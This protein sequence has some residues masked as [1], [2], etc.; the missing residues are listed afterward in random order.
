M[1]FTHNLGQTQFLF[2]SPTWWLTGICTLWGSNTFFRSQQAPWTQV[3]H[4]HTCRQNNHKNKKSL[5]C[6]NKYMGQ[7]LTVSHPLMSFFCFRCDSRP[8]TIISKA[9]AHGSGGLTDLFF[10]LESPIGLE[11]PNSPTSAFWILRLFLTSMPQ[12]YDNTVFNA[13]GTWT[14]ITEQYWIHKH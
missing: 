4:R 1:K 11:S 9:A 12:C 6:L 7:N 3:E 2:P 13:S 5:N 14:S 10:F 8:L